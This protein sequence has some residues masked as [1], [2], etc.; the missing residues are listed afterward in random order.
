MMCT[1]YGGEET[2]GLYRD[3]H[4]VIASSL[5]SLESSYSYLVDRTSR[6]HSVKSYFFMA[7]GPD[8]RVIAMPTTI[9]EGSH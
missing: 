9:L 7:E 1:I 6:S 5:F 3:L 8:C 4:S 2:H